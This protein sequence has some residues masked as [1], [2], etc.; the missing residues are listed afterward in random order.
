MKKT[1]KITSI[2]IVSLL[3]LLIL[4][5]FA[6][7]GKIDQIV[8]KQASAMLNANLSFDKLGISLLRYFPNASVDLK[9]IAITGIDKFEGDTLV[10]A[11]RISVVV[12]VMSLFD[13]SFEVSK[14]ILDSPAIYATQLKTGEVNWDIMKPSDKPEVAM[15]TTTTENSDFKLSIKDF[16]INK[17]QVTYINQQSDMSFYTDNLNIRMKG[18]L[19][20]DLSDVKLKGEST[21]IYFVSGTMAMLN[22]ADMA[23]D[24]TI[25]ADLENSKF[26][27]KDNYLRLNAIEL[28]LDGYATMKD[29]DA[30][31]MDIKLVTPK[32]QF[33]E[34]LS[35]IP[36]FYTK[37]FKDL[38]ASGEL[39]LEAWAKGR[40]KG[41]MLPAFGATLNVA[42]GSFKYAELPKS[43]DKI[44]IKA[45]ATSV[46]GSADNTK[47]NVEKLS[48]EIAGNTLDATLSATTPLSDLNFSATAKGVVNLA[49][50][51]EVYPLGDSINLNGVIK[52][53][54]DVAGK[55]SDITN[56]R[57]ESITANGTFSVSDMVA[58][59]TGLP[60]VEVSEAS[61]SISPQALTL[62]SL[63]TK[64]GNSNLSAT[65]SLTNYL[66]YVLRN[67]KLTGKLNIK[68]KLI[69]LNELLGEDKT[70]DVATENKTEDTTSLSV[71]VVPENLDIA[72]SASID[73]IKFQKMTLDNFSGLVTVANGT[74]KMDKLVMTAMGGRVG[75]GGL[76]STTESI[77]NP[78]LVLGLDI[79]NCSFERTF[80]EL[81]MIKK[82]VPL[83]EKTG[84]TYSMKFDMV[85]KLNSEMSPE[86]MTMS[87]KGV[88]TTG[89]VNIQNIKAFDALAIALNDKRLKSIQAKN[90]KISFTV[91]NGLI[92]TAPFDIKLGDVNLNLSGTTGL[93]QSINYAIKATLPKSMGGLISHVNATIG[94]TFADPKVSLGLK[95]AVN[96]AIKNTVN[97]EIEKLT[98]GKSVEQALSDQTDK[99]KTEANEK[100]REQA[101]IAGD[102]LIATAR[103]EGDKLVSKAKNP[104]AKA[105]AQK[106]AEAM[107]KQAEVQARKMVEAIK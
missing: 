15:D 67:D 77:T 23:L 10:S 103:T 68:S 86:L 6:F 85:T 105:L 75:A 17:G 90:V 96:D 27:F 39:S 89:D 43:V 9:N 59:L 34:L 100:L 37:D 46:G 81:D 51:K 36:A 12:N 87:A 4:I 49:M 101:Q 31:E 69:D 79:A 80:A 57:Y 107:V 82:L 56:K 76:Y 70:N 102:K 54:I 66:A 16:R 29:D 35:M 26:T 52:A 24:I 95:E 99:L 53:D 78:T 19:A 18:D 71:F 55:M 44:D 42:N 22:K 41:E 65:G 61:A 91:E 60:T 47:L 93:D 88:L 63:N 62:S 8:K 32:L 83:F 3:A 106:S 13:D 72:M 45:S 48:M 38:K 21:N 30:I 74:V 28:S 40:Y 14:L 92:R 94:G 11:E 104:I 50:I 97:K 73:K 1:L 25:E 58:Q 5:P 98:G 33:K 2:V 7:R 64:I 84:G 20:A